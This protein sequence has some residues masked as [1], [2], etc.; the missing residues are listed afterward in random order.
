M[1]PAMVTCPPQRALL[2]AGATT[3]RRDE[4]PKA[5]HA[6]AAVRKVAMVATCDEEHACVVKG[7]AGHHIAPAGRKEEHA[8]WCEMQDDERDRQRPIDLFPRVIRVEH[9]RD[10]EI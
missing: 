1:V 3:K 8:Q 6:V 9:R 5:V 7:D 10:L 2:C 4:G